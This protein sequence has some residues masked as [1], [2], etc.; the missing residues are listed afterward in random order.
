MK[1]GMKRGMRRWLLAVAL[2]PGLAA[3]APAWEPYQVIMW[4]ART[5]G[6]LAGLRAMGFTAARVAAT[7][8]NVDRAGRE[9]IQ[10][11][12]LG[13]YLENVAT[14]FYAPYHRYTAGK[15]VTWAFDA[16][17]AR[18]RAGDVT[19]FE[20]EPGLL[21]A[22]WLARVR[23]RLRDVAAA[24]PGALF[25]NLADESGVG[26]LAAAWDA[27]TG[28]ASLA[29][30][31]AWLQTQ[32]AT[33]EA[34]NAQWG[35]AFPAW[36]SVVPE[37]TDAALRRT[38]ENYSAWSDFKAWTD[39]AFARAV[40]TGV[41]GVHEGRS[42]M[43]AALEGGQVPGWGGYD[44]AL[45]APSL[46]VMEIYDFGEAL[47]LALAFNPALIPLRTSF[48]RGAAEA[49]ASWRSVL[50]GGRG[51][52]VWDE[53]DDVAAPDGTPGPR[54]REI[55]AFAAALAPVFPALRDAAPDPDPVAILVDQ[56]SFRLTWLLDRRASDHDWAARDAERE[57]DDNAW[58]ASRRVLVQGLAETGVQ[59]AFVST[60]MVE[61]GRLP[62]G[63]KL[64]LLPHAIALSDAAVAGIR[65]FQAGGG[66]VLA[67]TEPGV[68]DG[69][70]RRR[71][72]LPLPDVA[73][74]QA[75]R[76]VGDPPDPE[77]LATVLRAAGAEPRIRLLAPDGSVAKGV[78]ARWF[79]GAQGTVLAL[80]AGRPW[81]AP[82]SVT[83]EFAAPAPVSDLRR[84]GPPTV[85]ARH[86]VALDGIEPRILLLPPP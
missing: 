9:A 48:G 69:H 79:K 67:D 2:W 25:V 37:L 64:L 41:E 45:L 11:V 50:H 24:E 15:P 71:A 52:I 59:P 31:R 56:E 81:G 22:A 26:D 82:P 7:G 33:V 21:D 74:P 58:R 53:A 30:M 84:P 13:Y 44:Y 55:A 68:F 75:V 54:G 8:G 62:P 77:A 80:Q 46:D 18:L 85:S 40:R 36:D 73:H 10:A 66:T 63:T 6:Q 72:T 61:A 27:D 5:P 42:G 20:R 16:A 23:A 43:R 47:D 65:A 39:V 34:L 83:L 78:E 4:Q 17:K 19:A 38:D 12:D 70:G 1:R 32:Y 3:A 60:A 28:A 86:D 76:L 49:H 51:M 57:Y 29:G 35:T 14:D